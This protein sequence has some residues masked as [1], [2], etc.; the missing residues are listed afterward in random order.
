M[1]DVVFTFDK[2]RSYLIGSKVIVYIDHSALKYLLFKTD[3]KSILI[4]WILLLQE[5]DL[6]IRGK[7]GIEN[8][9]GNHLSRLEQEDANG[10]EKIPIDDAFLDDI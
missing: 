4:Q 3:A 5:F 9:G 8:L 1:L 7:K 10:P 2:F 6:E